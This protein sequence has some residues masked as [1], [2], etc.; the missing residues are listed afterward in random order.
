[1]KNILGFTLVEL[2]LVIAVGAILT[3]S[4]SIPVSAMLK[5]IAVDST[6]DNMLLAIQNARQNSVNS[7]DTESWGVCLVSNR[8]Y[9]FSGTCDSNGRKES[10]TLQSLSSVSGLNTTTFSKLYAEPNPAN[11]LL[12]V[13]VSSGSY[14]KTLSVNASG[15]VSVIVN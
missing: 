15:G 5:K 13:V 3:V 10:Y 6:S 4:G 11:G 7:K 1:M 14:S 2:A 8:I 12:N 9:V